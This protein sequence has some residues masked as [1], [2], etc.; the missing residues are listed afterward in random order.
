[1]AIHFSILAWRIPRTE[2]SGGLQSM[3]SQTVGT[4]ERLTHTHTHTHT[5]TQR[6]SKHFSRVLQTYRVS[7]HAEVGQNMELHLAKVSSSS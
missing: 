4:T 6:Q 5:H 1:M 3:G 2:K 7:E